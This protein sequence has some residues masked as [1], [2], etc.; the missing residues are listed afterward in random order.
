MNEEQ[1]TQDFETISLSQLKFSPFDLIRNH[2]MLLTA[3]TAK[4]ANSMMANWGMMGVIWNKNVV[5]VLVRP[6]RYTKEFIDKEDRFSISIFD[7]EHREKLI[8]FGSHSGRDTDKYLEA[9]VHLDFYQ[10]VP[11]VREARFVMICK[12]LYTDQFHRDQFLENVVS[13]E[14]YERDDF[15]ERIVAEIEHVM[16]R[17]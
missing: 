3:G 6:Q 14:H 13:T 5:E 16:R 9:G 12:K 11:Y 4:L 17:V 10:G 1:N 2:G 15:H 7:K 8:Y